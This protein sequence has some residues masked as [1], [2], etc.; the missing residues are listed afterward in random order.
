MTQHGLLWLCPACSELTPV[1][2][3]VLAAL[4][5]LLVNYPFRIWGRGRRED[6]R[7]QRQYHAIEVGQ[8]AQFRYWLLLGD[9][10]DAQDLAA[11]K[12]THRQVTS[13]LNLCPN[14]IP[15]EERLRLRHNLAAQG[16]HSYLE[17]FAEDRSGYAIIN[18]DLPASLTCACNA[19]V[20]GGSVLVHSDGG[21]D[22]DGV[23]VIA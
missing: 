4:G 20:S 13:V 16:V 1:Q 14:H 12:L 17:L 5:Q 23:F 22:R 2:H 10:A 7:A 11:G 15:A 18:I 19:C 8:P 9:L 21:V 3:R 6:S